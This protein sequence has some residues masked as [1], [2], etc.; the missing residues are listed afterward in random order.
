MRAHEMSRSRKVPRM[1]VIDAV[2]EF[3]AR[4]GGVSDDALMTTAEVGTMTG[5]SARAILLKINAGELRAIRLSK[6]RFGI[7]VADFRAWLN[8]MA[9]TDKSAEGPQKE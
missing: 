8:Q 2:A 7:R 5:Y 4:L 1:S 3:R 6:R 9:T